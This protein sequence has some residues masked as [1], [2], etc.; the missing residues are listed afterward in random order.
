M[1]QQVDSLTASRESLLTAYSQEQA[2]V[3]SLQQQL[4]RMREESAMI[5][6]ESTKIKEKSAAMKKAN[7]VSVKNAIENNLMLFSG[8]NG[9]GESI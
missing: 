5:K 7:V 1:K 8:T 6:E 9:E 3:T 4:Q 2:M